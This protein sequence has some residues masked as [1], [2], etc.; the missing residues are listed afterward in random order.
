[1]EKNPPDISDKGGFGWF[2]DMQQEY[3]WNWSIPEV[4]IN[5]KITQKELRS[6]RMSG[7]INI[8][9]QAYVKGDFQVKIAVGHL[10]YRVTQLQVT[11]CLFL[12]DKTSVK[13]SLK[14]KSLCSVNIDLYV[15]DTFTLKESNFYGRFIT[16][17]YGR[18]GRK[19]MRKGK[20]I[21]ECV[22]VST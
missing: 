20:G 13:G 9:K 11:S 15:N 1:M 12:C 16:E 3:T 8:T 22:W 19:A 7:L 21:I 17:Y 6:V 5:L 18:L 14:Y 4:K 10:N 2:R